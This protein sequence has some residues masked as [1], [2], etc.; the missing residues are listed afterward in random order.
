MKLMSKLQKAT[1]LQRATTPASSSKHRAGPCR[2][3]KGMQ[4]P[5]GTYIYIYLYW[6]GHCGT[7]VVVTS[8]KICTEGVKGK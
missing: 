2:A 7:T 3:R 5:T 8:P 1:Q 4:G 6:V